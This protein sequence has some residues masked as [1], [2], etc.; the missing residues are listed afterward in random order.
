MINKN[1][2]YLILV[3]LSAIVL[4]CS[5]VVEKPKPYWLQVANDFLNKGIVLYEKQQYRASITEFTHALNA[6]QRFDYVEGL[7]H[8]Y[9]NLAKS[10]IA[11][12][13]ISN[14]QKHLDNLKYLIEEYHFESMKVLMDIMQSSIAISL[15]KHNEAIEISSK[16]LGLA[17]E[18]KLGVEKTIYTALLTNRV[19]VA[20]LT[21]DEGVKW[22]GVYETD[23]GKDNVRRARLLRFK[24]QLS[25]RDNDIDML[26]KYFSQALDLYREQANPKAVLST[27]K[28]WGDELV[29]NKQLVEAVRRFETAYKV[30]VSSVNEFEERNILSSLENIYIKIGD[31]KNLNKVRRLMQM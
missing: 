2:K 9:L 26:N 27:L 22:V 28:E 29:R 1:I 31:E 14:A 12:N 21:N 18:N 10:E 19:R 15:T 25:S 20:V 7:A 5:S 4:A 6:Y 11:Q 24:G 3:F 8:C 23:I 30:A 17:G 16:Y 13:N